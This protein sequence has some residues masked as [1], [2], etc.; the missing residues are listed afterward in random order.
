[1]AWNRPAIS[2]IYSRIINGIESRLTG[3]VALLRRSVLRILAKV[4]AGEIHMNYGYIQFISQQILVDSAEGSYLDRHALIWGVDRKS[5]KF[6]SGQVRFAG[7]NSTLIPAGTQ[8]QDDDG[9]EYLTML[10]V[11]ISGGYADV[12]VQAAEV[13][14]GSDQLSGAVLH[15]ISPQ[16]GVDDEATTSSGGITGGQDPETD[17]ALR[18]RILQRI[19]E[20]PMGGAKHDYVRWALEVD[21]VDKAWAFAPEDE[22][23][24]SAGIARVV[25]TEVGGPTPTSPL[26]VDDGSGKDNGTGLVFQH[27]DLLK[28]VTADLQ[29]YPIHVRSIDMD[30][31]ITPYNTDLRTAVQDNVR[32]ALE[33]LAAPG[34]N[35]LI[36]QLRDAIMNSGVSDYVINRIDKAGAPVDVDLDIPVSGFDYLKPAVIFVQE[37]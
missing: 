15:M 26:Y 19:Q 29:V 28:P 36:S 22:P 23:V 4:F 21:G 27:I 6:S 32:Q 31:S 35:F 13:G 34:Q 3:G 18:S 8:I 17:E 37:L 1:M 2:T 30:I 24:V 7:V 33:E 14:A 12:L 11:T 25:F 5:G 20:P 9:I 10:D 16:S